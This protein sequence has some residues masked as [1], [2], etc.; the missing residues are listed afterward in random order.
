MN[1]ATLLVVPREELGAPWGAIRLFSLLPASFPP[2]FFHLSPPLV[3]AI[4]VLL[5][6]I[7]CQGGTLYPQGRTTHLT[8]VCS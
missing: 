7:I 5:R 8:H 1:P 4:A 2:T 6:L 3:A